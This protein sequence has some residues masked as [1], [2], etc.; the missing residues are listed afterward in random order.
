L[1]PHGCT[2]EPSL[3]A[4]INDDTNSHTS[5]VVAQVLPSHAA[6]LARVQ[7]NPDNIVANPLGPE[8]PVKNER[9][10]RATEFDC[11]QL[12]LLCVTDWQSRPHEG[13]RTLLPQ[14]R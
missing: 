11:E 9:F 3:V 1:P 12:L 5:L 8:C 7:F 2:H 6:V 13:S 14:Q 4:L 10:D